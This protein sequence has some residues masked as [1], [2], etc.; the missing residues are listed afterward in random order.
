MKRTKRSPEFKRKI[1]IEALK[2]C[3]TINEIASKYGVH[4]VQVS[5]WKKELEQGA[6]SIFTANSQAQRQLN[7]LREEKLTFSN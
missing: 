3:E 2:E 5:R 1:A 7:I 6:D 4:P